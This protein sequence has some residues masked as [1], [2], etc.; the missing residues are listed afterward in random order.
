M[1]FGRKYTSQAQGKRVVEVVC[2]KCGTEFHFELARIGVGVGNAP[3]FLF[4]GA[5]K[6]RAMAAAQKNLANK[7]EKEREMVPCPHCHW[8]NEELV[9]NYRLQKYFKGWGLQLA[10]VMTV[11]LGIAA[12][13]I[14]GAVTQHGPRNVSHFRAF[15][16]I[17]VCVG[18][19]SFVFAFGLTNIL[20]ARIDPNRHY[21]S[22]PELPPGTPPAL[23]A[24]EVEEAGKTVYKPVANSAPSTA[25]ADWVVYRPGQIVF[26][27]RCCVCL[28]EGTRRYSSPFRL[29]PQ[30]RDVPVPLCADCAL[31]LRVKWFVVALISSGC[32]LGLAV[33]IAKC[34]G[35][36]DE[37]FRMVCYMLGVF[38]VAFGLA[39]IPNRACRPYR[40]GVVDAQRGIF[41][42]FFYNRK[43]TEL[44]SEQV[45]A[46]DGVIAK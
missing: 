31:R 3:Y 26:P 16:E 33:L 40:T 44:V 17:F 29:S 42:M 37:T 9:E 38:A 39:I 7:L 23:M 11:L 4:P 25:G 35:G 27:A 12:L 8:I 30:D 22:P 2:E 21:P 1:Y 32:I 5:A 10:V 14:A 24:T 18:V 20:R 43:F 45:L 15:T 36:H 28:G 41:K 13:L 34:F 46:A 6:R 19:V